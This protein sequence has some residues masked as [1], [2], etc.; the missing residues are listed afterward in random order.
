MKLSTMSGA[1]NYA[2]TW[3]HTIYWRI[4]T[5]SETPEVLFS[6]QEEFECLYNTFLSIIPC[7]PGKTW[8]SAEKARIREMG[9]GS[10]RLC[11]TIER[12]LEDNNKT[13]IQSLRTRREIGLVLLAIQRLAY[14]II[15]QQD[16]WGELQ[17]A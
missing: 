10:D 8:N 15:C 9:L 4:K 14:K 5:E 7:L 12:F 1:V 17:R 3:S 16:M 6:I 2:F 11:T 13:K